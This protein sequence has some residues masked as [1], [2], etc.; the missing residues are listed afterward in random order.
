MTPMRWVLVALRPIAAGEEVVISYIE[1]D[2]LPVARR[3][4][5][6]RRGYG[7]ECGCERCVEQ[8]GLE[9]GSSG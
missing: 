7:F 6:L 4:R 8:A 3:R 2:M 9:Q 1:S 5:E